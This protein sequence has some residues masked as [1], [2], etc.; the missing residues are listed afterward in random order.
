MSSVNT[1]PPTSGFSSK[2]PKYDIAISQLSTFPCL[3]SSTSHQ[4]MIVPE[5]VTFNL[6]LE[7]YETYPG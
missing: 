2:R 3:S 1:Y 5:N 6:R 7:T 4:S